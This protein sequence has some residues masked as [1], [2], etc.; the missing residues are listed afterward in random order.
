VWDAATDKLRKSLRAPAGPTLGLWAPT[1]DRIII[2]NLVRTS[3]LIWPIAS[4]DTEVAARLPNAHGMNMALFDHSGQRIT[5]ADVERTLAVRDLRSG[6]EIRLGGVREPVWDMQFSPDGQRVAA[7]TERGTLMVWRLDRP[8]APER[9]LTGHRGHINVLDYG[10]NGT[11][12]TAGQDRTVRVWD[13]QSRA[14]VV[15]RGHTDEVTSAIF[16]NDGNRVLSTSSDGTLR[17]W[18][19]RGGEAL[20]VL[21]S[22]GDPLYEVSLS[23]N[24]TLATYAKS[25]VVRVFKCE[26]CGSLE[27]L[28]ALARSRAPQP[29]TAEERQ[30]FLAAAD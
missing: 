23:S 2:T 14:S 21:E 3:I 29:L 6:R 17:L 18:D 10:R 4:T 5:Y 8:S 15:L 26:V 12:V 28:Q 11:V 19:A 24:G 16:T 30:R 22:G 9:M 7:A 13:P 27:E 20:A 1:S 25:G